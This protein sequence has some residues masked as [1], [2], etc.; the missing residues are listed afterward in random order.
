MRTPHATF[1]VFQGI[2]DIVVNTDLLDGEQTNEA[3]N[4]WYEL[5]KTQNVPDVIEWAKDHFHSS[6]VTKDTHDFWLDKRGL[7]LYELKGMISV[8]GI[9][10][11][12]LT[13]RL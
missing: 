9:F 8:S 5:Y 2:I 7:M 11:T 6:M 13:D 12:F 3:M 10:P 1:K 4:E